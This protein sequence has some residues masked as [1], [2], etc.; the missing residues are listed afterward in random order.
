MGLSKYTSRSELLRLKAGGVAEEVDG[1]KQRLFDAG[2]ASERAAMQFA[3]QI[4]GESLF[5]AVGTRTV[6]GLPLLASFDGI[7]MAEDVS[8]ENKLLNAALAA[9]VDAGDLEPHYWA[10]MEHQMLV[11]GANRT[12]FTASDGTEAGTKHLWYF[13]VPERRAKVLA[14]W[15]QFAAD[16]AAYKAPEVVEPVR[17][18]PLGNLPAVVINTTG[19]LVVA[20]N[21]AQMLPA[22]RE[23]VA[24][25]PAKP[26][27][28]QDFA[29]CVAAVKRLEECEKALDAAVANALNSVGD[30]EAMQ[31]AA[32][33][34]KEVLRPARLAT[35]KLV[36]ARK[37]Q[38]RD[39]EI[40]RGRRAVLEHV[41][42]LN[43]RL[44]E[45]YMPQMP[46]DFAAAIKSLRTMDSLRN[47]IDTTIANF[48]IAANETAD[49]IQG[50][51]K[52]LVAAGD[53]AS[54]P[55]AAT[56]VLKQPDD[57]AAVIAQ[58]VAAERE[59]IQARVDAAA[60]EAKR[61]AEALAA[62]QA[63]A[64]PVQPS[65]APQTINKIPG[66]ATEAE[67]VAAVAAAADP[68]T[69]GVGGVNIYFGPG[70]TMTSEF[71]EHTLGVPR[72]G[73][74]P[75]NKTPAWRGASLNA[76]ARALAA[77]AMKAVK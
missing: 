73:T 29:D 45:R 16:L 32:A 7:T 28:D 70:I 23:F 13:S 49:R 57:L 31:R 26:T 27:T 42:A 40:A 19:A 65:V 59:R 2:H 39:E 52:A 53:S 74:H 37:A 15:R 66:G 76:I 75:K 1:A 54:F 44:G 46:C 43:T 68:A 18:N 72:D 56:L 60:A 67:A 62:Q 63:Q 50:N 12:L 71:I 3:E 38:I 4:V 10:Q 77:H 48:K 11:S 9:Q 36:V 14:A 41:E 17:A 30:I 61:K 33:D 5:P 35:E 47:A 58:R 55:D 34:L 8:W 64:V 24:K 25:I 21:L 20:S 69:L 51:M 22:A 6:D